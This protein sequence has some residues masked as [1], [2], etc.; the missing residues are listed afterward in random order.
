MITEFIRICVLTLLRYSHFCVSCNERL[1]TFY[2]PYE[3]KTMKYEKSKLKTLPGVFQYVHHTIICR[4]Y[5]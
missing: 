1:V 4:M 5:L 3:V 2:K